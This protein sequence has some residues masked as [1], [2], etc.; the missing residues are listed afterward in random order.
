MFSTTTPS[1]ISTLGADVALS[2]FGLPSGWPNENFVLKI[3]QNGVFVQ[4]NIISSAPHLFIVRLPASTSG[5]TFRIEL[6]SPLKN[7]IVSTVTSQSSATP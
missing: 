2:G 6:T 3:T 7:Q 1:V 5:S 4:P